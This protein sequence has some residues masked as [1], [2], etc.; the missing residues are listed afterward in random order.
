MWS[1]RMWY[2]FIYLGKTTLACAIGGEYEIPFYKITAPQLIS[3]LSGE[4]E[5]KIRKLFDKVKENAPAILFIDEIDSILGKRENAGKD[6]ERRIVAQFVSSMDD[7]E[8]NSL[9]GP[10]FIIGATSKPEFLDS[11]LRRSGRFDRVINIGF[12]NEK[13]REEMLVAMSKSKKLDIN[14]SFEEL[15]KLTA[16]YLAADLESLIRESGLCAVRRI[17][18]KIEESK[19][20][21]KII[22]QEIL[23]KENE[24]K[25]SDD[26]IKA[27]EI[28]YSINM[29]DFLDVII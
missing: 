8:Y 9:K 23:D 26:N 2:I 20:E 12:P 21:D 13:S 22:D 25:N 11:A 28:V 14:I 27:D 4:S 18:K 24:Q 15:S 19:K 17:G 5:Q 6:M 10:I 16:G 1:A 3:G 7:I 29:D